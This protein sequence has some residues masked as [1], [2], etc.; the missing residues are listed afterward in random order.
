NA[1][2]SGVIKFQPIQGFTPDTVNGTGVFHLTGM[3][4]DGK[5]PL[6][7][8]SVGTLA[9]TNQNSAALLWDTNDGGTILSQM[10]T[11]G[12]P[13]TFDPPAA[14]TGR[15]TVTIANGRLNGL[16]DSFV[17]YLAGPGE[18]FILDTSPDSSNRAMVG[19]LL[20]Q[21]GS[22]SFANSTLSGNLLL[23][24]GGSSQIA[25]PNGDGL[26]SA[27]SGNFNG[28][29]DFTTPSGKKTPINAVMAPYQ[30]F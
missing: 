30:A 11:S 5:T 27:S 10:T 13:V 22:G 19:D 21:V 25:I 18:G 29:A 4:L 26:L 24:T 7:I 6:P 2:F 28:I 23:R 17:F 8:V 3:D 14:R 9:I 1:L 16:A 15:G 20:P 12:Q